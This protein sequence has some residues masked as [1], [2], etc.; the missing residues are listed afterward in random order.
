ME[1]LNP[2]GWRRPRGYSN[3]VKAEGTMVFV[4][5]QIGWN[6]EHTFEADGFAGQARQALANIVAVL[7]AAGGGP[8][9]ITRMTWYVIDKQEYLAALTDVGAAYRDIIGAHYPAMTLV[10]VKGLLEDRAL[11]EIEAQAMLPDAD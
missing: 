9:H 8:Q 2:E 4:A 10:E 5:G 7:A 1:F 11:V 3:G 6:A